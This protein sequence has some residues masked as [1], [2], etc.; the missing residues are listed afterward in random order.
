MPLSEKARLFDRAIRLHHLSPE[1]ILLYKRF[2]DR[3]EGAI[4]DAPIWTGCYVAAQ[5]LRY[6][7]T[8]EEEAGE[9]AEIALRGLHFLQEVTGQKGLLCR[10]VSSEGIPPDDAHP[11]EWHRGAE[12]WSS[13]YWH[14]DVS[15][16]QYTGALFGYALAYDLLPDEGVKRVIAEDVAAIADHLIEHGMTI[17]DVDGEVTTFGHLEPSFFTEDLNALIA[18][19]FFKIAHHITG[20]ARFAQ[21]YHQLT[22]AH[23]Y[24]ERAVVARN[25]WWETLFG[26]N[27]SDNNL[28]FLAYYPLL[29]YETDAALLPY[30]HRSLRRTWAAVHKEGNPFFSFVYRVFNPLAAADPHAYQ[31]LHRFPLDK[32]NIAVRNSVQPGVCISWLRARNGRLQACEPVAIEQRPPSTFEWK[33]NPYRLDGGGD[34]T[35]LYTGTDYL[36]AY[37]LGRY[38][39]FL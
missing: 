35:K 4:G 22:T 14:G 19:G 11:Q 12:P 32:R 15:V 31:T 30:Y 38:H 23:H 1:G 10:G 13:Y 21:H 28:A 8:R 26:T 34:G 2:I 16:D 39:G 37:W 17:V 6:A 9:S 3:P 29:R 27:H 25:L 20:A 33:E 36:L 24:H 7:V 18:L 5:A